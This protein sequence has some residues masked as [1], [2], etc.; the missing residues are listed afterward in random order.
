MDLL[1]DILAT[2]DLKGVLYFRTDFSPPWA[3]TVPDHEQA[4]RFHLLVRGGCHARFPSGASVDLSPGDLL[5]I[6]G[7]RSHVLADRAESA[8]VAPPLETVM[9]ASGYNGEGVFAVG[10]CDEHAAT[11]MICG[12]F[13]FRPGADHPILRALPEYLLTTSVTRAREPWLDEMLRLVARRM[14]SEGFGSRSTVTRLSEVVFV[15][16]LRVGIDGNEEI[17]CALDAFRDEQIGRALEL[18]H[19]RPAEAWTVDG[20]ARAVGM[21]R[22]RFAERFSQLMGM[23]PMAYLAEWRLQKSL[24]LLGGS[25]ASIAQVALETGYRS[26]AAFTRAFSGRFGQPPKEYRRLQA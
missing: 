11:Q 25:R 5:L 3:V 20:L 14:F 15:E 6:P 24:S 1:D 8:D 18:I 21:S 9:Q 10:E 2:L 23:G 22:S 13:N 16:L 12:H 4:A 19:A 7:G 17:R 26:A